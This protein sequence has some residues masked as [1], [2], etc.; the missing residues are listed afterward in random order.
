MEHRSLRDARCQDH[1]GES[2]D[3]EVRLHSWFPLTASE[4]H[5]LSHRRSPTEASPFSSE[6]PDV[7]KGWVSSDAGCT[8]MTVDAI[9]IRYEA[10]SCDDIWVVGR[11]G[12]SLCLGYLRLCERCRRRSW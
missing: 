1:E 6:G 10:D 5:Q 4:M 9:R 7:T 3:G 12:P 2:A 11:R 8:L